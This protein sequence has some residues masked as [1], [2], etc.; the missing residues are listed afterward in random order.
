MTILMPFYYI[1]YLSLLLS[2]S[3]NLIGQICSVVCTNL[4]LCIILLPDRSLANSIHAQHWS[5]H[6][7]VHDGW[8]NCHCLC[9]KIQSVSNLHIF[10]NLIKIDNHTLSANSLFMLFGIGNVD[11]AYVNSVWAHERPR[12][13]YPFIMFSDDVITLLMPYTLYVTCWSLCDRDQEFWSMNG[14][15]DHLIVL[16]LLI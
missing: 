13:I 5:T 16:K 7:T 2:H 1:V 9:S 14:V 12:I 10:C 15:L 3:L 6:R 11:I 4:L 8:G